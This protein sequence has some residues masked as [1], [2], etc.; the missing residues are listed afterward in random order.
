MHRC[1]ENPKVIKVDIVDFRRE[2]IKANRT[3]VFD[4]DIGGVGR[5]EFGAHGQDVAPSFD[6][7]LGII[8]GS[9]GV[10]SDFGER[11]S[12]FWRGADNLHG[13]SSAPPLDGKE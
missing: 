8:P 11:I 5:N 6:P 2:K 7:A 10:E 9:L 12:I 4:C 1:W 3:A 13:G